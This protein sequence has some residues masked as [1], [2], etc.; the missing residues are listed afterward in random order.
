MKA[1]LFFG[2]YPGHVLCLPLMSLLV[3]CARSPYPL[4]NSYWFAPL[5][6]VC[7]VL[8]AWI[9]TSKGRGGCTWFFLCAVLGPIGVVVAAIVSKKDS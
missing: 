3:G 9:A 8:G 1:P 2:F 5:W 7:G 6:L 4:T